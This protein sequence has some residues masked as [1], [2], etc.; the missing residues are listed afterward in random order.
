MCGFVV[1]PVWF[2]HVARL[3]RFHFMPTL[4]GLPQNHHHTHR[5]THLPIQGHCLCLP[6]SWAVHCAFASMSLQQIALCS[7]D[8]VL[9]LSPLSTKIT[10][11]TSEIEASARRGAHHANQRLSLSA[12]D[13]IR[14]HRH[15]YHVETVHYTSHPR[16]KNSH[17]SRS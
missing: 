6:I 4:A 16:Y 2:G 8:L 9:L 5:H 3:K 7:N 15:T 1:V 11:R 12:A 17:V 14:T 10:S 13:N